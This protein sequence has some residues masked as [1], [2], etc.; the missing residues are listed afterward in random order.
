VTGCR[1]LAYFLDVEK[2][3]PRF[4]LPMTLGN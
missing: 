3:F 4:G 1:N 2:L